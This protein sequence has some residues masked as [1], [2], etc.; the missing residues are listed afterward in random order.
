MASFTDLPRLPQARPQIIGGG[1]L[2]PKESGSYTL[3][4]AHFRSQQGFQ[5]LRS[6]GWLGKPE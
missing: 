1:S 5:K 6:S 3:S 2:S 4:L